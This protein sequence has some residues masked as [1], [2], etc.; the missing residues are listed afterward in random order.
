[1]LESWL[2]ELRLHLPLSRRERL[3]TELNQAIAREDYETA[4]Q[5]R[6]ALKRLDA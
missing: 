3:E 1:M 6:D 5:L 4:A 2:Q